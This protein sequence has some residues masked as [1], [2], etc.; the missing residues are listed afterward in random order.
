MLVRLADDQLPHPSAPT[1]GADVLVRRVD[2]QLS[3]CADGSAAGPALM[4][5]PVRAAEQA[6]K[7]TFSGSI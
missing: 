3:C 4:G 5:A 7:K 2:T 6:G 1:E